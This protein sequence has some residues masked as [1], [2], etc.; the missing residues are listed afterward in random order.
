MKD[1]DKDMVQVAWKKDGT[2]Y[3]AYVDKK[4]LKPRESS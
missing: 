4:Y 1:A 3:L 2:A